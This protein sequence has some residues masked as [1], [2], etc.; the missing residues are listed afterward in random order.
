M[1]RRPALLLRPFALALALALPAVVAAQDSVPP[2]PRDSAMPPVLSYP[3]APRDSAIPPRFG[4][5]DIDSL[6]R[7]IIRH[8]EVHR[9]DIF[10]T[11]EARGFLPRLVNGLHI[12]TIPGVVSREVLFQT[13]QPYDSAGAAETARNL[14]RLGLFR[15]VQIDTVTTD[16]GFTLKVITQDGWSPLPQRR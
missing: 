8:I 11:T 4:Y 14:R 6:G 12:T 3:P 10:D 2:A 9:S 7:P 16:T 1:F 5:P 13:G 15:K